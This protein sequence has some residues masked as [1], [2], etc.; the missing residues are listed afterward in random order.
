[1]FAGFTSRWIMPFALCRV[2]RVRD[3]FD[4]PFGASGVERTFLPQIVFRSDPSTYRIA[5][6]R[7]PPSSPAS[8]TGRMFGSS[9][10]AA[11]S[12]SRMNRS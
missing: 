9:S 10:D 8:K 7:R 1:M 3:L 5:M 2:E 6:N 11:I 12:D 4:D